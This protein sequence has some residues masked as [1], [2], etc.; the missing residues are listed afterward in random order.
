MPRRTRP[1]EWAVIYAEVKPDV[2]AWIESEAQANNRSATAEL[3]TIIQEAKAAR[4]AA[5]PKKPKRP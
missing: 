3:L 2:K 4:E 1:G 5:R